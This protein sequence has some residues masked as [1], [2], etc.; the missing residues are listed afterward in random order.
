MCWP[1]NINIRTDSYF[2]SAA[3]PRQLWGFGS[4]RGRQH[5]SMLT[6]STVRP[7]GHRVLQH[8]LSE[9]PWK[10]VWTLIGAIKTLAI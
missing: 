2:T 3:E 6:L 9:L 1:I 4:S 5:N 8:R 7:D 10:C